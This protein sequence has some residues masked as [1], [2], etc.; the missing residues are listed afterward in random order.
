M[1]IGVLTSLNPDRNTFDEVRKFGLTAC[2]IVNWDMALWTDRLADK[3]AAESRETGVHVS[4]LWAGWSGPRE[5][6][7]TEG[8]ATLG[9]VPAKWRKRRVGDLRKAADFAARA[10]LPA[11]ITHAGF[12]P[13]NLTDKDYKPVLRAI[14]EVG[15]HCRSLGVGF[16]FETGQET[17][18]TLLRYIE[19]S[20]LDNLG[21]NL[22]PANL[23][24]YGK[25]SPVDSLDVFGK[26]VR[27]L[28]A[29]DGLYPVDGRNL[30]REV[31]IGEGKVNFPAL[32]RKLKE[33][34]YTGELTIE[35][36][37]GG[38]EQDR[39]IRKAIL[40]LEGWLKG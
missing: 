3:V 33:I 25:G 31:P 21:V 27:D 35:R 39:D 36:E 11:I 23:I 15:R 12:L 14:V 6:N 38:E 16:W 10:G 18:V 24:L 30:G 13:E 26:Y 5:W 4:A 20:G 19:E 22:D 34:G 1:R 29:K 37:I 9:L 40:D 7:F 17:P 32:I 8:P 28:H 2:Q